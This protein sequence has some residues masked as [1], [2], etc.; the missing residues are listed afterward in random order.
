MTAGRLHAPDD[1]RE[2]AQY[3]MNEGDC[4]YL[5]NEGDCTYLMNEGDCTPDE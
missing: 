5:M 3:L 1:S 2:T 4:T